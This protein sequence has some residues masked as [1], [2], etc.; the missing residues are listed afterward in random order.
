[1][2]NFLPSVFSFPFLCV[3]CLI[4]IT[5]M[6]IFCNCRA[7]N[8]LLS[9][10]TTSVSWQPCGLCCQS[11]EAVWSFPRS[12][13]S[14]L[15]SERSILSPLKDISEKHG[16]SLR[17]ESTLL[18]V[19]RVWKSSPFK[20]LDFF[21]MWFFVLFFAFFIKYTQVFALSFPPFHVCS[22]ISSQ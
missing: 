11:L 20:S 2:S 9:L 16:R 17:M 1:M 7:V 10:R 21:G 18:N 13:C 4:F 14:P 8:Q 19:D 3:L 15:T 12:H 6:F 5:L 22:Y